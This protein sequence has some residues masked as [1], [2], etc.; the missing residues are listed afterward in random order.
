M[1]PRRSSQQ[2]SDWGAEA[3]R[4]ETPLALFREFVRHW[5]GQHHMGYEETSM[6]TSIEY[7]DHHLERL[8]PLTPRNAPWYRSFIHNVRDAIHAPQLS[9]LDVSSRPVEVKSIWGLYPRQK[10]SWAF[11]L[12]LQSVIV[13]VLFAAVSSPTVRHAAR[14]VFLL[15]VPIDISTHKP[16]VQGGGG[17]GDRSTQPASQGKLAK[18]ALKQFTPPTAVV[19][20]PDAKLTIDPS[21]L[22][23]PDLPLPQVASN[24]YGDPF[25]KLL[26]PSNGPG[27]GAGIGTGTNG[28][29]GP[30][31]GP[32][33]G[34]GSDGGIGGGVFHAGAGVSAPALLYKV[35]P[36]YS[37]EARKAKYQGVVVL[38]V[39]VDTAGRVTNPRV[40]RSLGLGLDEKAIEA[41]KKWKFRPGYKDG[42]PVLVSA[43]IEVSFRLL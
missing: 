43:E 38:T 15:Q 27:S 41:V 26:T 6:S 21:I 13:A 42:R 7:A 23:P 35:E 28:G 32:G 14:E 11:S 24:I 39:I 29:V 20:N 37:E 4:L 17:G 8:L 2:P 30:G 9:L 18:P 16:T 36:E 40:V 5:S 3:D 22:V 34:P 33:V 19:R 31:N 12:A 10:R 25:G 1:N